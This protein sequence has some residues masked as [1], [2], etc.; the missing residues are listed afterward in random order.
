MDWIST[1]QGFIIIFRGWVD[2][3][4]TPLSN[5]IPFP[6]ANI[7]LV[8][9]LILSFYSATQ[10]KKLLPKYF[11]DN[12]IFTLLIAGGLFWVLKIWGA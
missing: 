1:V 9:F 12:G 3:I 6:A 2:K 10:I 5:F 8:I 11:S 4:A 7:S